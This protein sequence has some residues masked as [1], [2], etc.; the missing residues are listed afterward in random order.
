M[1]SLVLSCRSLTSFSA[2]SKAIIICFS[3]IINIYSFIA[4]INISTSL[5][6]KSIFLEVEFLNTSVL[7]CF[8][9]IN[10]KLIPF[11]NSSLYNLKPSSA[12]LLILLTLSK[13]I[14]SPSLTFFNKLLNA[15]LPSI[16]VP[17]KASCII[18]DFGYTALI[19]V[20]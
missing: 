7:I 1:P 6:T 5:P 12:F 16:L 8:S 17:V 20:I 15:F 11:S 10:S 18:V 3:A 4:F 2:C 13:T 14:V 9:F 19:F